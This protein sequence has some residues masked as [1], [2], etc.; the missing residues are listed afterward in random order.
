MGALLTETVH[1]VCLEAA[2]VLSVLVFWTDL[3]GVFLIDKQTA[4]LIPLSLALWAKPRFVPSRGSGIFAGLGLAYLVWGL[5]SMV[6]SENRTWTLE[7]LITVAPGPLTL[8]AAAGFPRASGRALRA[9]VLAAG[10]ACLYALVQILGEDPYLARWT[11]EFQNR[12]FGTLGNPNY[13]GGLLAPMLFCAPALILSSRRMGGP[14]RFILAVSWVLM[15]PVFVNAS[16]RGAMLGVLAGGLVLALWLT[17]RSQYRLTR[18]GF[19]I[20]AGIGLV[21]VSSLVLQ[22]QARL[23]LA[24]LMDMSS[25]GAQSRLATYEQSLELVR[26]YP[27]L[28]TGFGQFAREYPLVD[29]SGPYHLT[30]HVHN[31][32]L[33]ALVEGGPLGLLFFAGYAWA[34]IV[35]VGLAAWRRQELVL[36]LAAAAGVALWVHGQFFFPGQITATASLTGILIAWSVQSPTESLIRLSWVRGGGNSGSGRRRGRDAGVQPESGHR[37]LDAADQRRVEPGPGRRIPKSF[38]TPPG[39][40]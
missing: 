39:P 12:A 24:G 31:E 10:L 2:L 25:E 5:I 29:G 37:G 28:G 27:L 17:I 14:G 3:D 19:L 8:W 20:L 36:A 21:F 33:R 23:R 38:S 11:T 4:C 6:W 15:I 13:L 35:W 7:Y 18:R 1:R 30:T 40:G 34:W 16:V 22:P 9:G 32:G 26:E